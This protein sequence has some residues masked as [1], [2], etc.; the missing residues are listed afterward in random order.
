MLTVED[1]DVSEAFQHSQSTES[2]KSASSDSYMSKA[3][4]AKRRANQ[5]E[6]EGFYFTVSS[7]ANVSAKSLKYRAQFVTIF[8]ISVSSAEIQG[9]PEWQQSHYQA[10]G[11]AWPS[12]ADTG[13]RWG[14]LWWALVEKN[15]VTVI[16]IL[17]FARKVPVIECFS[18]TRGYLVE[19]NHLNW[20]KELFAYI[21][22]TLIRQNHLL[23]DIR[24][25]VALWKWEINDDFEC[26]FT[27]CPCA[28]QLNDVMLKLLVSLDIKGGQ[29]V[30]KLWT[31]CTVNMFDV[32]TSYFRLSQ[33]STSDSELCVVDLK[34]NLAYDANSLWLITIR[35]IYFCTVRCLCK[36][37]ADIIKS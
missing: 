6:T 17:R 22:L 23:S 27:L 33:V 32:I 10:A 4:I 14:V 21:T 36:R 31:S 26:S 13:G 16:L 25:L 3:N 28:E 12:K 35:F 8:R 19:L 2:V 18:C 30:E 5:Q 11:Q 37:G 24:H 15:E 29:R 1:F 20:C 34:L 9:V 7:Q